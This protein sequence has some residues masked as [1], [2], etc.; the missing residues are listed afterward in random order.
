MKKGG[1]CS[2]SSRGRKPKG[3]MAGGEGR[4][5]SSVP[6]SRYGKDRITTSQDEGCLSPRP[7]MLYPLSLDPGRIIT[8]FL[9]FSVIFYD[10]RIA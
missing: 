1:G 10:F 8:E 3:R 4:G 7:P 5:P 2:V 6:D 9:G